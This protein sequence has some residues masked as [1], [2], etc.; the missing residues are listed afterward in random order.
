MKGELEWFHE[1]LEQQIKRLEEALKKE[2]ER[3]KADKKRFEIIK[4][5]WLKHGKLSDNDMAWLVTK[6]EKGVE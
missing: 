5:C 1:P 6:A 4:G 3:K 2:E